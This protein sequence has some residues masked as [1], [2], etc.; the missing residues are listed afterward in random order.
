MNHRAFFFFMKKLKKML[1]NLK[2]EVFFVRRL[3]QEGFGPRYWLPYMKNRFF[4]NY[5]FRY[6]PRLEY[7]PDPDLEL[8][9]ICSGKYI[10]MFAWMVRSFVATS[11][12][13]PM[14]VIHDDGNMDQATVDLILSKFPNTTIMLREET[15]QR[16]LA[17][18]GVPQI[19]KDVRKNCHFFLD[20]LVNSIIFSKAKRVII[21]D[22]D[23]L[24]FGRPTE[25]IDFVNG[26]SGVDALTQQSS[27][28]GAPYDLRMDDY[29]MQK[30]NLH[31]KRVWMM[32]GG[33]L[34]LDREKLNMDQL[35]EYFEH[36]QMPYTDYFIEMSG[37]ACILGQLNFKFLPPERYMIK[38]RPHANT[39]MKHF[40]SPRRY[41]M[42]AY[43][44]DLC[45]KSIDEK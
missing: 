23:I 32:N 35:V 43:G 33:Y 17:M 38:N 12:L 45:R 1:N 25:V 31:E 27:E 10:W 11:G 26:T 19:I 30:Y 34:M 9:T 16:I 7:T 8:H 42:F 15:T 21:S 39:A 6:L 44:F 22:S 28:A 41:E 36:V 2:L 37:W 13:K 40:T 24:Y 20:K 5:L 3:L 14:V 4:G 29:Y 18:P